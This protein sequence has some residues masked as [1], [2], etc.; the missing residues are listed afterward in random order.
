M[1]TLTTA[2]KARLV[3]AL[4]RTDFASFIRKTFHTLA[5][6]SPLQ[7]N[8]HIYALAFHLELV[9]LGVI[10][11]LIINFPPRSLK[12]IVASVAFPAFVLGHDPY[13]AD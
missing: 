11:R 1:T 8:F 13:S 6:N 7:M 9:R 4:C 10:K 12:S 2:Q 5:P 3:N